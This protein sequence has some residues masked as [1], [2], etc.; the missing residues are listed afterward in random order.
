MLFDR[1]KESEGGRKINKKV[2]LL[3]AMGLKFKFW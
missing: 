2:Y 3:W 1:Q